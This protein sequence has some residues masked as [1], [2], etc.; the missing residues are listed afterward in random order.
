MVDV[1]SQDQGG[2]YYCNVPYLQKTL[3]A[4]T[5]EVSVAGWCCRNTIII[6]HTRAISYVMH[7][8]P[9]NPAPFLFTPTSLLPEHSVLTDVQQA[10]GRNRQQWITCRSGREGT[11]PE[12]WM[13]SEEVAPSSSN[14]N[15]ITMG[16]DN[17]LING[18]YHC[19]TLETQRKYFSLFFWGSGKHTTQ[20]A[21]MYS[22]THWWGCL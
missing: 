3:R 5:H 12:I 4:I 15:S 11:R 1:T 17:R 20:Y 21:S 22:K 13:G 19:L 16:I 8:H 10:T 6:V 9:G 14:N 7:L 2:R 18:V